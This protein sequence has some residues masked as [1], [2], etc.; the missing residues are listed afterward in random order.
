MSFLEL[1]H[2]EP[3]EALCGNETLNALRS[4]K[5][6]ARLEASS[7]R[8]LML[9]PTSSLQVHFLAQFPSGCQLPFP[10]THSHMIPPCLVCSCPSLI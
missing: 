6:G 8:V 1:R 5:T 3:D 7:S 10:F 9:H 2:V 4:G